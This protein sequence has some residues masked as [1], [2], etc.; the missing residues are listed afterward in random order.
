MR[1]PREG[2]PMLNLR[3]PDLPVWSGELK[4]VSE[5][6]L[7]KEPFNT[8]WT[9]HRGRLRNLHPEIA[10]Q[11]IYRHWTYSHFSFLPLERLT[12]REEVWDSDKILSVVVRYGHDG[13][14][15]APDFDYCTFRR[16]GGADRLQTARALD[17]GTWDFAIVVLEAPD[18]F[19]DARRPLPDARY[20][21]IEGHQRMRY[22]NA[23]RT[24]NWRPLGPH[25][26]FVLKWSQP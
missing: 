3:N 16:R 10:E 21:L 20:V 5:G 23:L 25:R 15:Y 2:T 26:V 4:P 14:D 1:S 12:W 9:R 7:G 8:W 24:R 22:L 19:L 11:W 18:G 13:C 17:A 6:E